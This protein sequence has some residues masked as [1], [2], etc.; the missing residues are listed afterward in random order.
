MH[1]F[2]LMGWKAVTFIHSLISHFLFRQQ[3][4]VL[5]TRMMN[6]E[7]KRSVLGTVGDL[8]KEAG[9]IGFFK[10]YGPAFVRLAPHTILTFVFME[11]LR[12]NFGTK[13]Q[14]KK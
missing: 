2:P 1:A 6:A 14:V 5:K 13:K 12:M 10:G 8:W 3:L 11:Q 7:V 4:D 9:V